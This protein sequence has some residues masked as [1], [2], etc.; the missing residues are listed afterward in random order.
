MPTNQFNKI[1]LYRMAT[2]GENI[3]YRYIKSKSINQ[4]KLADKLD[5]SQQ[6]FGARLKKKDLCSDFIEKV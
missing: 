4:T 3:I 6:N 2:A 1:Q 5:M